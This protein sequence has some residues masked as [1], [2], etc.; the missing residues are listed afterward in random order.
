MA[1]F[2][3]IKVADFSWVV[4]GPYHTKCL[5]DFGATVIRIESM[6][7]PDVLRY[8]APYKDNK[9]GIN[10]SGYYA[11]FNT[12]KYS[13]FLNLQHQKGIEIARKLVEWADIVIENFTPG[14]MEGL[15]LGF[16][17]LQKLNPRIIMLRTSQQGVTGPYAKQ[18]GFGPFLSALAGFASLTGWPDRLPQIP[19][20]PYTDFI[21]PRFGI[22]ALIAALIYRDSTG[23]GQCIDLSQ[24]ECAMHF[25]APLIL[26]YVTNGRQGSRRGN[27]SY[28]APHNAYLCKGDDCWCAI[29]VR[30]DEEWQS[31]CNAI[32]N[33][34]WTKE[35]WCQSISGRKAKEETLDKLISEWTINF[36]PEEV[37]T[38]LQRHDISAG[39]VQK[40]KDLIDDPQLRGYFWWMQHEE[41]GNFSYPGWA[42]TLSRTPAEPKM[43]SPLMGKHTEFV[44]KQILNMPDSEFVELLSDG[45]LQ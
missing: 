34:A 33:P 16:S 10:R 29:D 22:P 25:L 6:Q 20:G 13:M 9:P 31:L 8:S 2:D 28:Y 11:F 23:K 7:R 3:G 4:A 1:I 41:L 38:R 37:M 27:A 5:A 12:N 26:D 32:G 15:G 39:I 42:I 18:L 14:T 40:P 36:T 24:L 17:E 30:T 45:V 21:A 19:Y 35:E 43:P 44:C